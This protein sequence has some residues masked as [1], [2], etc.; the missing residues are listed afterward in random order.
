MSWSNYPHL[1][2]PIP[3]PDAAVTG[4]GTHTR[5]TP[6]GAASKP[7]LQREETKAGGAADAPPAEALAFVKLA[8]A[9]ARIR[10][11]NPETRNRPWFANAASTSDKN[12]DTF[13]GK[14]IAQL[15]RALNEQSFTEAQDVLNELSRTPE[16]AA[17]VQKQLTKE[18]LA[19][20]IKISKGQA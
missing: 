20:A 3:I 17:A 14:L 1:T 12:L 9:R 15:R 5:T 18:N 19:L 2:R 6:V 7:M 8:A 10:V 13:V 4:E 11:V 16:G